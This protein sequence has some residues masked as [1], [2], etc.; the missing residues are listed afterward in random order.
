MD[1]TLIQ[2]Q[3]GRTVPLSRPLRVC[4]ACFYINFHRMRRAGLL[5]DDL[6]PINVTAF[7]YRC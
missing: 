4:K 1:A 5:I 2:I 7:V 3:S 6:F